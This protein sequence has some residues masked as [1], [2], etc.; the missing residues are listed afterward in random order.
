MPS[1][2]QRVS[3]KTWKEQT[4]A[5]EDPGAVLIPKAFDC[6]E[7]VKAVGSGMDRTLKFTISTGTVDREN[8]TI[9]VKGWDLRAFRK[10]GPILWAHQSRMPTIGRSLK[11]WTEDERLKSIGQFTPEDMPHP[12]GLG[13]GHTVYRMF[14]EKYLKAVSVGF[15]PTKWEKD[16]ARSEETNRYAV[17]FLKQE[18]LEFSPVPVPANP[19]ALVEAGKKGIDVQP[20]YDWCEY[21]LDTGETLCLPRDTIEDAHKQLQGICSSKIKGQRIEI[22]MGEA[23]SFL[24]SFKNFLGIGKDDPPIPD[25]RDEKIAA[26]EAEIAELKQL[27]D[28]EPEPDPEPTPEPEPAPSEPKGFDIKSLE[29]YVSSPEGAA[30]IREAL[31]EMVDQAVRQVTGET[32]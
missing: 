13:F 8:D 3:L 29:E 12:L 25:E 17:N 27:I 31:S 5:G 14:V 1:Q 28:T 30:E 16:E 10:N 32:D 20:I 6:D 26:L 18:L 4:A 2:P 15:R 24:G 11:I 9:S 22:D 23:K 19:E 7:V 21:A